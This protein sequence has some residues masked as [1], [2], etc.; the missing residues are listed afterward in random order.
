MNALKEISKEEMVRAKQFIKCF[1][2]KEF[3]CLE[4]DE[5][6]IKS[7]ELLFGYEG[8]RKIKGEI[9]VILMLPE[10]IKGAI[11]EEGNLFD[12]SFFPY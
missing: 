8:Y 9:F 4:K 3:N 12:I 7:R 1:V 11:D 2:E 10:G 5:K 6:E